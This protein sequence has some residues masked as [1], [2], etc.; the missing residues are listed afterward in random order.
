M[1]LTTTYARQTAGATYRAMLIFAV[2]V[3]IGGYYYIAIPACIQRLD[4]C[5]Q[6][7]IYAPYRHRVLSVMLER[8]IAPDGNQ[9]YTLLADIVIHTVCVIVIY[10]GLWR[11]LRQ[12][13]NAQ[14]AITGVLLV[15]CVWL[16]SFHFYLRTTYTVLEMACIV[17]A[18]LA[19]RSRLLL[20]AALVI[21]ASLNRETGF[22]LVFIWAAVHADVLSTR[23]YWLRGGM[24]WAVYGAVTIALHLALGEGEHVLG[25]VGTLEHNLKD[26]RE[27]VLINLIFAPLWYMAARGYRTAPA[28]LQRLALVGVL[29]LGAIVVAAAWSEIARLSL[30]IWPLMLPVML[31]A[32]DSNFASN[33]L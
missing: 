5:F 2:L 18:L 23:N 17:T 22:F 29:Y 19:V 25:L 6:P 7:I 28:H 8:L 9:V 27:A 26:I 21:L 31:G 16:F 20:Y 13:M 4:V 1:Q 24:L 33:R 14:A 30:V 3:T 15:A 32:R 12:S 10:A 11:W